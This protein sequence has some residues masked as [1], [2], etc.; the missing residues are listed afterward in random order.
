MSRWWTPKRARMV[1]SCV[2]L[3]MIVMFVSARNLDVVVK[4]ASVLSFFVP[5]ISLLVSLTPRSAHSTG[6]GLQ[7]LLN[8]VAEDL[9]TAVGEQWRAEERLR[10]LQ[11][12][13]P[14]PVRW[15]AADPAVTDHWE[16]ICG[17]SAGAPVNLDGQLDQVVD[18]FN[19]VPSRRFVVLGKPGGGKSVLTLRFTL[20]FLERRQRRDR[21]PIIFPLVSW[22]PGRQSLHAWM[23][24][25]LATDYP[26]LGALAPSGST[27]AWELVHAARVLPVLD[28]LDEIPKPLRAQ[29]MRQLNT[30]F[31]RAA[32][33]VLTSRAEEYRNTVDAAVAFTSAA[34]VELQALSLDDISNYLPRTTRQ[35]H[36]NDGRRPT[37]KW[38]PVLAHLRENLSE[39]TASAVVQ[40]LSTPLM[41]SMARSAYSD[42]DADPIGLL[43]GRF[44]DSC[45]LE[46]HLLDA[47]IP[48]AYSYH[49]T[50][51]DVRSTAAGRRYRPEQAQDWLRFLARQMSQLGT[52][53]L[54]W[55]HQA[56]YVSRLTR[57]LLAGLVSG[58]A[59]WLV[60]ELAVGPAFGFAYGLAFG[61]ASG[62]AHGLASLREPSHVEIRFRGTI[63]PFLRR[64][65][66]GLSIGLV[67]GLVFVLPDGAVLAVGLTFGL[68]VGLHVWL[69]IPADVARMSSPAVVLKQDRIATLTFGLS[70]ALSFGLIYGTAYVFTDSRVGGPIFGPVLGLSFA[71]SFGI[72]GAVAGAG[73]GWLGYGRMGALTYSAAG[74]I[75]G[76]LAS[77]PVN[78]VVLG[79]AA[80]LTFGIAAG[81]VVLPS[82]AWGAYVLSRTWLA[83]QGQ[84]PW[85]L[86]AFLADAHRRG[87]LR[88]A[89]G[90]YQFRHARLQD[91]LGGPK[92]QH[93]VR[94]N[95]DPRRRGRPGQG[96]SLAKDRDGARRASALR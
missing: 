71:L 25:R 47:F 59:F 64:F 1:W 92:P 86:M 22:H 68:A 18:V 53:D 73:M 43:D 91:H 44:A 75:A 23:S 49:P 34:V 35:I 28:G 15:T 94:E 40:V 74:A 88:Q 52:R 90:V 85:R 45:A 96:P 69:D 89:G 65:T 27:W 62:L 72:A 80:G 21:V 36:R 8:Q 7:R 42:T 84:Q 61:V 81:A 12:P 39:P 3:G 78:S 29:A 79:T 77:P 55:W 56:H 82:R 87:V 63:K 14:L 4:L 24:D 37:T 20:Q 66:V 48:A 16:N 11:D 10:R 50:A 41:T 70:F 19:R 67:L 32:P 31:D 58:F 30:A 2:L 83:A 93:H 51:P 9:A 5:L 54:A 6:P 38:E 46:E 60:G 95:G 26:A 17:Q 76:G 57:G 33:V 13:F